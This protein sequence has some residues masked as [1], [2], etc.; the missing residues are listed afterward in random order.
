MRIIHPLILLLLMKATIN[1]STHTHDHASLPL[2]KHDPLNITPYRFQ[3]SAGRGTQ[4]IADFADKGFSFSLVHIAI[5]FAV[6]SM[7]IIHQRP[8]DCNTQ[9]YEYHAPNIKV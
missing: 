7:N 3:L 2:A 8:W 6:L 9:K 4:Y 1:Y 5:S